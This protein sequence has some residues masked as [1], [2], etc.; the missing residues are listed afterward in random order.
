MS[1]KLTWKQTTMLSIT[2]KWLNHMQEILMN[3]QNHR[4]TKEL[5]N[6][7]FRFDARFPVINASER[8]INYRF[9]AAEAAYILSGRNNIDYVSRI[10][11][12]FYEYSDDGYFQAGA[13]GPMVVDQL[14]YIF[15]TLDKDISSRQAVLTIWRPRPYDSKDIPCTLSMQFLVRDSKLNTIVNMRSSDAFTGLVYD[16]FCF[17]IIAAVVADYCDVDL[18][19]IY[20]NAGSSHIYERDLA[21][22]ARIINNPGN[23]RLAEVA[24]R[25]D[26]PDNL[27][28]W[29]E[30]VAEAQYP[31]TELCMGIG[32]FNAR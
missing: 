2:Y 23:V 24:L 9:M 26:H 11:P 29:L 32:L 6:K 12:N 16:T 27:I 8:G 17:S 31:L 4:G 7:S 21:R 28:K 19:E 3:G 14:P 20:I 22:A 1:N 10:L 25:P 30:S 13:Y 18:G 5:L 15:R